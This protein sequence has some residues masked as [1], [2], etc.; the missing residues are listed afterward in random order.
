VDAKR[1]ASKSWERLV[2]AGKWCGSAWTERAEDGRVRYAMAGLGLGLVFGWVLSAFANNTAPVYWTGLRVAPISFLG[3]VVGMG[4]SVIAFISASWSDKDDWASRRRRV[5]ARIRTK[6]TADPEFREQLKADWRRTVGR[7]FDLTFPDDFEITVLEATP[8]HGYVVL[9][10]AGTGCR[11][12]WTERTED[13]RIRY[14]LAGL[15]FGLLVGS[16]LSIVGD[17]TAWINWTNFG[18][19][20]ISFLDYVVGVFLFMI[21][22]MPRSWTDQDWGWVRRP[23]TALR[24]LVTKADKDPDFREQLKADL[25]RTVEREF[26]SKISF[27]DDIE[28]TVLEETLEHEYIVL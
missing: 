18:Y 17:N 27:P 25:R 15:G 22:L 24:Q 6:A 16:V 14:A 28:I 1:A 10:R 5:S 2:R 8:K 9:V 11:S 20:P 4:L 26:G 23:K 19:A 12:A 13:G 7:E 3:F 21:A